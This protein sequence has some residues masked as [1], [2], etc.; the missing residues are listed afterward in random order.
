[1]FVLY[2]LLAK[3]KQGIDVPFD[4]KV[5]TKVDYLGPNPGFQLCKKSV[6]DHLSGVATHPKGQLVAHWVYRIDFSHHIA[7]IG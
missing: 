3:T 4:P 2:H 5:M 7:T 1:M 6:A